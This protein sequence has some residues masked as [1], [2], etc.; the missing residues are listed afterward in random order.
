MVVEAVVFSGN[1]GVLQMLGHLVDVDGQAVLVGMQGRHEA[2]VNIE[3]LRRYGRP[4]IVAYRRQALIGGE[5]IAEGQ[6][7]DYDD[8]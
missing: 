2:A 8:A 3:D 7:G 5:N 6:A 1:K 4:H